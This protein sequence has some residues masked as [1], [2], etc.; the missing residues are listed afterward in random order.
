MTIGLKGPA[1]EDRDVVLFCLGM[2]LAGEYE[3]KAPSSPNRVAVKIIDMLGEE[4][5]VVSKQAYDQRDF[6]E[7]AGCHHHSPRHEV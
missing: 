2:Q 1:D 3:L 4:M 5:L 7:V 6:P